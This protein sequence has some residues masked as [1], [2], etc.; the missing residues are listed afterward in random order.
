MAKRRVE[1]I[2]P[3]GQSNH[4]KAYGGLKELGQRASGR[5]TI[6]YYLIMIHPLGEVEK[7]SQPLG[8]ALKCQIMSMP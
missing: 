6:V 3:R 8:T 5:T 2:C 7:P 1:F 4:A